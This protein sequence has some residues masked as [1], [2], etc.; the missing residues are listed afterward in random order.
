[1][2]NVT[3]PSLPISGGSH[4][5]PAPKRLALPCRRV[6]NLHGTLPVEACSVSST[7]L[8]PVPIEL[9]R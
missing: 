5:P 3:E 9:A 2:P 7:P 4:A 1:M 6:L 8:D